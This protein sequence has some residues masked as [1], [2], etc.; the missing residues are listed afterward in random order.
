[1]IPIPSTYTLFLFGILAKIIVFPDYF[2]LNKNEESKRREEQFDYQIN[3]NDSEFSQCNHGEVDLIIRKFAHHFGSELRGLN[4]KDNDLITLKTSMTKDEVDLI[5]D[6]IDE[7]KCYDWNQRNLFFQN[8]EHLI[9]SIELKRNGDSLQEKIIKIYSSINFWINSSSIYDLLLTFGSLITIVTSIFYFSSKFSPRKFLFSVLTILFLISIIWKWH[10]LYL[11]ELAKKK[12]VE[13]SFPRESLFP[14]QF[15]LM[16]WVRTKLYSIESKRE[17]YLRAVQVDPIWEV[18]PMTAVSELISEFVLIPLKPLGHGLGIFFSKFF[19]QIPFYLMIPMFLFISL[20]LI[21]IVLLLAFW[22]W[23]PNHYLIRLPFATIQFSRESTTT[24][25]Y[26]TTEQSEYLS[27]SSSSS[28]SQN[29]ILSSN[30]RYQITAQVVNVYHNKNKG[31]TR[32]RRKCVDCSEHF[33]QIENESDDDVRLMLPST[34]E[35]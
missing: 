4:I 12:S 14:C 24:T 15:T 17:E 32:I 16:N 19:G 18:N 35:N 3:L 20:V 29:K 2:C 7:D 23:L 6:F 21:L 25:N 34:N 31:A 8:L 33:D 9:E 1:M 5:L 13:M 22:L 30:K 11:I 27:S 10:Q 26:V 28:Q